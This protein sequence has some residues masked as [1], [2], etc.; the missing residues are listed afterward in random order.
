MRKI[1]T[2][3]LILTILLGGCIEQEVE[4]MTTTTMTTTT[5][6]T[7]TMTTTTMNTT[8]MTTTTTTFDFYQTKYAGRGYRQVYMD[9]TFICPKCVL[10][11]SE[12]LQGEEGVIAKSIGFK[13]GT[14]WVIYDPGKVKLERVIMIMKSGAEVTVLND[15]EIP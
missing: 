6:T 7:T 11:T 9:V 4:T 1:M 3:T 2:L 14:M 13:Q 8:T 5:M 10:P 12:L 15:T